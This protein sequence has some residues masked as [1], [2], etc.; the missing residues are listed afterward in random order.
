MVC[1]EMKLHADPLLPS[2][3]KH[4][5][6]FIQTREEMSTLFRRAVIDL[7]MASLGYIQRHYENIVSEPIPTSLAAQ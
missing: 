2:R 6:I 3:D 1:A 7:G 5:K 4:A